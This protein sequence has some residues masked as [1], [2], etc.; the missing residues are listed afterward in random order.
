M[1]VR[2]AGR[3]KVFRNALLYAS[4]EA[5]NTGNNIAVTPTTGKRLEI[6]YLSY[7]PVDAVTCA[8]RFGA[9]GDLFLQNP[10]PAA[11]IVAKD[12]GDLRYL[13]GDV[14]EVLYLYLSGA[15]ATTWN[16]FYVEGY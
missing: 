9:A 7:C 2:L 16:V 11:G 1:T 12:F 6:V 10:V 3:A 5:S 8:W 13:E 4:G 15:V 14:D